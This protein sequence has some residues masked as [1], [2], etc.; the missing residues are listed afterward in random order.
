MV[1]SPGQASAA[2]LGG[3]GFGI[4]T[5]SRD[6]ERAW[7]FV[8]FLSRAEQLRQVQ[9]RQ[10]RIPARRS[11]IP[12]EMRPIL[13]SARPR[14]AIPEYA[15]ASDILQRWL[16]SALTGRVTPEQAMREAARETSVLLG[17]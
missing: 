4:S 9:Q 3:W 6:P 12:A 5:Y 11:L 13:E 16:S 2:T 17:D 15:Q 14:P 7:Q 10:G 1:H 8:E